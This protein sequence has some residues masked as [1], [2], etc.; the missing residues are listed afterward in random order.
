[1]SQFA[2][3]LSSMHF[4]SDLQALHRALD[5]AEVQKNALGAQLQAIRQKDE[6]NRAALEVSADARHAAWQG[7]HVF[8]PAGA[9]AASLNAQGRQDALH[10]GKGCVKEEHS[11]SDVVA[12]EHTGKNLVRAELKG[13]LALCM[14]RRRGGW[15]DEC[16]TASMACTC[17]RPWLAPE[18]LVPYSLACK[19][20]AVAL[21]QIMR[22]QS[23]HY[24][25]IDA[26]SH[27]S[28]PCSGGQSSAC[29]RRC[30][31]STGTPQR[32]G[33]VPN[34]RQPTCGRRQTLLPTACRT[35]A[36]H[37]RATCNAWEPC[38]VSWAPRWVFTVTV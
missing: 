36:V 8:L 5:E 34:R 18:L 13:K 25:A 14:S 21:C 16:L 35:P 32:H 24:T 2:A 33:I 6:Q 7:S 4:L 15:Q 38:S 27:L 37:C 12:E 19:H 26:G 3:A 31:L 23:I 10:T 20:A 1:M 29:C 28:L 22:M 17:A 9:Q 30:R 11:S